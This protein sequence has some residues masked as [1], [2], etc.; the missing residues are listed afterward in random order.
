[1]HDTVAKLRAVCAAATP[2]PW[3]HVHIYDGEELIRADLDRPDAPVIG[4]FRHEWDGRYV[5][6]VSP[7]LVAKLLDVVE[8]AH[9]VLDPAKLGWSPERQALYDA[10]ANLRVS[11]AG[12]AADG[13]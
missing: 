6:V 8:A 13:V 2:G 11:R 1:M 9:R 12:G 10:L 5:G 4:R 3:E 7:D